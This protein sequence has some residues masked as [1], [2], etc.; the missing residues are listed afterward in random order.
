MKIRCMTALDLSHAVAFTRA[1]GPWVVRSG[2]H[3]PDRLLTALAAAGNGQSIGLGVLETSE[4]AVAAVESL[5]LLRHP[6]PPWRMALG[7]SHHLGSSTM[8]WAVG[9][10]AKG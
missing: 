4:A 2:A 9:S 7:R 6:E 10:A 1:V 3:R 8:S 5:G